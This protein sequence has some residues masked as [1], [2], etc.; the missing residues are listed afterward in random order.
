MRL[1]IFIC[2]GYEVLTLDLPIKDFH[3][4]KESLLPWRLQPPDYT[5]SRVDLE[6]KLAPVDKIQTD[7]MVTNWPDL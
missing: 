3:V 2:A 7:I 4:P 5:S 6:M 1:A